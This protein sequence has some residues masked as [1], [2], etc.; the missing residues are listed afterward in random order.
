MDGKNDPIITMA[1]DLAEIMM[2]GM[3][4]ERVG[5]LTALP[6]LEY[7]PS[8][9]PG[10]EY[11]SEARKCRDMVASFCD[12]PFSMAKRQAETGRLPRSFVLDMLEQGEA[13][14]LYAKDIAAGI[15]IAAAET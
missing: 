10:A 6:I 12:L 14:G 8:W 4:G 11:Q 1:T 5:L 15:H 9:F 3:T 2:K 13:E 7:V